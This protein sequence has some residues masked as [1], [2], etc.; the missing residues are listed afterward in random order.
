MPGEQGQQGQ[1]QA[2]QPLTAEAVAKLITDAIKPLGDA[3]KTLGGSMKAFDDKLKAVAGAKPAEERI[4]DR[5]NDG[6]DPIDSDELETMPR[7]KF[8]G[9]ILDKVKATFEEGLKPLRDD[10]KTDRENRLRESVGEMVLKAQEKHKDFWSWKEEMA[11]MSKTHPSLTPE[12]L[13]VLVKSRD[14]DKSKQLDEKHKEEEVKANPP[15]KPSKYGGLPPASGGVTIPRRDM[16]FEE[17]A[18]AAWDSAMRSV[19][20][21][22]VGVDQ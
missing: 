10:F 18:E 11:E 5:R 1:Q 22:V 15:P 21:S 20:A 17:A 16:K 14:P 13:Y 12:D 9:V 7:E 4:T 19:P 6:A 3:V 8:M 2:S